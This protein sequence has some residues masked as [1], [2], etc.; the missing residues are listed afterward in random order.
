[1][2]GIANFTFRGHKWDFSIGGGLSGGSGACPAWYHPLRLLEAWIALGVD[3]QQVILMQ[4]LVSYAYDQ[5]R[6]PCL[7]VS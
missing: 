2:E 7:A 4:A 1:M 6:S 5:G 3:V